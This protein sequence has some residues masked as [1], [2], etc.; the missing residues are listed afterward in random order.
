MATNTA[1][2]NESMRTLFNAVAKREG[3]SVKF[4]KYCKAPSARKDGLIT[5]RPPSAVDADQ[6]WY[7]AWHELGHKLREM[8][9]TYDDRL[10]KLINFEDQISQA[11]TNILVDSLDERNFFGKYEG[12]DNMLD[13]GRLNWTM[14]AIAGKGSLLKADPLTSLLGTLQYVDAEH[15]QS[16]MGPAMEALPMAEILEDVHVPV[17]DSLRS[18]KYRE[19][20]DLL[21]GDMKDHKKIK[22]L[23]K[24]VHDILSIIGYEP[25]PPK[26][27]GSG[28]DGSEKADCPDCKG[29]GVG[30]DGEEC[31]TCD[32]EG[33]VTSDG[34]D[35]KKEG[36]DEYDINEGTKER[37]KDGIG[38]GHAAGKDYD[39]SD[40]DIDVDKV[41]KELDEDLTHKL[42]EEREKLD[43]LPSAWRGDG[44]ASTYVPWPD[45]DVQ[46]L[47][48]KLND[49]RPG[50]E[51]SITQTLGSSTVS[52]QIAKYLKAMV[53]ESWTYG[54]R[55]GRVHGKSLHKLISQRPQAGMQPT[56]YKQRSSTIVKLDSAVTLQ[57]DCS[58]SMGGGKYVTGAACVAALSDTLTSLR[59]PHEILGFSEHRALTTYVFKQFGT[60]M[61]KEKVIRSLSSQHVSL[62]ENADGESV[63]WAAER[64]ALRPEKN[65]LHIVLSDGSPAGCYS[66]DGDAYLKHVCNLI[67]TQTPVDLVGIG[68][69]TACVQD[70]YKNHVVVK[71][72]AE[73][74]QVL[75]GVLKNFLL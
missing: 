36:G 45:H 10:A 60:T 19:R 75:F 67:E 21:A 1:L 26:G 9:W 3:L 64:L 51:R 4:D 71:N 70:Y 11:V 31:E 24:L 50:M 27:S 29:T 25:P 17:Q 74:D 62:C 55:R 59:I 72:P 12:V 22:A 13:V 8:D 32:G 35:G 58:G 52:K 69:R 37:P 5:L 2:L 33:T 54:Q 48:D 18:L 57:L 42:G 47:E 49:Y 53:S 34:E 46:I 40:Q 39:M 66:G 28:G 43:R 44:D 14:D 7:E 16:F 15:R 65:K 68:I 56:I 23:A 6:Y 41:L 30:E 63:L 61:N 20:M 38:R 73:L